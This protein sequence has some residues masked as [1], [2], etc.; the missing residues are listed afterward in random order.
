MAIARL[1]RS[2]GKTEVAAAFEARAS[3]LA[4]LIRN[5]LWDAE[6][7]FFKVRPR[8]ANTKLAAVRELYGF[9]PWYAG[10]APPEMASAWRSSW[11][12]TASSL[13]FGPTTAERRHPG[14][15]L[16]Y[17]GH[18][19][20]WNGPELAVCDQRDAHGPRQSP[21]WPA[22]DR[23]LEVRLPEADPDLCQEPAPDATGW[24][25]RA[26]DRREPEPGY[27]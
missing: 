11:I 17:K 22:A 16:S 15:K 8:G 25:G 9:A 27:G 19:C 24:Q 5:R 12:Q 7:H 18:E 13:P 20:Q 3:A 6:A 1:A 21:E 10:V 4:S 23:H 2:S 26:L 14:F